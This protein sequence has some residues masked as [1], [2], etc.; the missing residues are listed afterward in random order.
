MLKMILYERPT[1]TGVAAV[2]VWV[3][4]QLV[5]WKQKPP[6]KKIKISVLFGSKAPWPNDAFPLLCVCVWETKENLTDRAISRRFRRLLKNKTNVFNSL[7]FQRLP[8]L[9]IEKNI[10]FFKSSKSFELIR[11]LGEN[12]QWSRAYV[13]DLFMNEAPDIF[14]C[15]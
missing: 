9:K 6:T 1:Y 2:R 7:S 4:P 10:Y 8:K 12:C 14:C 5:F 15:A 3:F 11:N 13:N